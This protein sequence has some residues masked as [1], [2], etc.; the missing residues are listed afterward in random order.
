MKKTKTMGIKLAAFNKYF[1][2]IREVGSFGFQGISKKVISTFKPEKQLYNT[3]DLMKI[4]KTC[5]QTDLFSKFLFNYFKRR[6]RQSCSV[7]FL[8]SHLPAQDYRPSI[9]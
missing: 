6:P 4:K 5:S 3:A 8:Q 1:S 2:R 7:S 9:A